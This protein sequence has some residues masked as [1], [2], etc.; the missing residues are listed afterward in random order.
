VIGQTLAEIAEGEFFQ[1]RGME[2]VGRSLVF[3]PQGHLLRPLLT[4]EINLDKK[5]QCERVSLRF[6]RLAQED[7]AIGPFLADLMIRMCSLLGQ[8]QDIPD[9]SWFQRTDDR[10]ITVGD[11]ELEFALTDDS[12]S[13]VMRRKSK[14]F[15]PFRR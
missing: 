2:R 4:V 5:E 6:S 12:G 13:F 3:Q 9:Q 1:S 8:E 11:L 7:P 14:G 15:W 10:E